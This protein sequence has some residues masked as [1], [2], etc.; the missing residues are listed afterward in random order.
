MDDVAAYIQQVKADL[1]KDAENPLE[2]MSEFFSARLDGYESHML[3]ILGDAPY[4]RMAELVPT[5]TGEL[6][7]L[8]C[9]TGLEL[10]EIFRRLP[11]VRVTGIDM[12]DSMLNV[13]RRKHADKQL[14]L[15]AGDFLEVPLE[16]MAFDTAISFEALHHLTPRQKERLYG[17]LHD[18]IRPGGCYIEGD[19]VAECDEEEELYFTDS[20]RRRTAAGVPEDAHIHYDTPLTESHQ[21]ELLLA[22]GFAKVTRAYKREATVIFHADKR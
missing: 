13:L 22:A 6:L 18:S 2:G 19:Y 11:S 5:Q 1:A 16:R 9:G 10:D 21:K 20:E 7:D 4:V 15:I 17:K 8:G 12:T 14:E 3:S